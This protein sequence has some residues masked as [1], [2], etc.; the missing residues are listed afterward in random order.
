MSCTTWEHTIQ[1]EVK[2]SKKFAGEWIDNRKAYGS[3]Y[4][5]PQ[6]PDD[7]YMVNFLENWKADLT[8]EMQ[9]LREVIKREIFQSAGNIH[10]AV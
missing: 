9:S 1:K 8:T 2:R 3:Y 7:K 6:I 5:D 4:L 10:V